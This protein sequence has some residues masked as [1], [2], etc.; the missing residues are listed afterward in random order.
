MDEFRMAAYVNCVDTLIFNRKM[1]FSIFD[2]F[3]YD[4]RYR[5]YLLIMMVLAIIKT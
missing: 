3:G 5:S 2:L 1:Y 4:Q